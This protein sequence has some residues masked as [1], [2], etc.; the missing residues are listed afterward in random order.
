M[1]YRSPRL[2]RTSW[3]NWG[4][5][6]KHFSV[7]TSILA[8][9][10]SLSGFAAKTLEE[11][12]ADVG[13]KLKSVGID[14]A[15]CRASE[16]DF[17]ACFHGLN[18]GLAFLKPRQEILPKTRI[19]AEKGFGSTLKDFDHVAVVESKKMESESFA[20]LYRLN[21]DEK[22]LASDAL[23]ALYKDRANRAVDFDGI[24][25]WLTQD[26]DLKKKESMVTG[27]MLNAMLGVRHD[28]HTYLVPKAV[29]IGENVAGAK[30]FTG[31]GAAL[32]TIKK[33][34][35]NI[36][37][38]Q[39]PLEGG[40]AFKAG[41]KANDVILEV[42]GMAVDGLELSKVVEKIKGPK[43]TTVK[44]K[45]ER[46]PDVLDVS[47]VRD[48]I[49]QKSVVQK[50][51]ANGDVGYVKLSDFMSRNANNAPLTYT[52]LKAAVSTQLAKSPKSLIFDLRD[53]GGGMLGESV[54]VASLFLKTGSLVLSTKSL[55]GVAT[56]SF[57]TTD[58]PVT[59]LPLI[60]LINARSAS[61]SE[62]VSGALQDHKRAFLVGERTYGKGTVQ[63]TAE[64][65]SVP[66]LLMAQTIERFYLPSGRTNQ[67][68]GV[69]PDVEVFSKPNPSEDDK[70]AYREEDEYEAL[71][72][73]GNKWAQPRPD[74]IAKLSACVSKGSAEKEFNAG[75]NAAILPDYQLLVA[76]DAAKCAVSEGL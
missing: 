65:L 50:S 32:K 52:E 69:L 72:S 1:G 17:I 61:A 5:Y 24:V 41:L 21:K 42:D 73:I 51:F 23:V 75:A 66:E 29:M 2:N 15:T 10:F 14:N 12:W 70:V 59:Q 46:G 13:L 3:V 60:V 20:E 44:L 7:F 22:K 57:K 38:I 26:P 55:S 68:E 74:V 37:V 19:S 62:I 49:E 27:F 76:Q 45:I 48:L 64:L 34:G 56:R 43:G 39:Q 16:K 54:R 58:A 4:F 63:Q 67:V 47:I 40:P 18:A 53:N 36:F 6:L 30:N 35:K 31:I 11:N 25:G 9:T 28:P 33:N 8:F 71:P